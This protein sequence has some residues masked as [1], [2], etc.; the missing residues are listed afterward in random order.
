[1]GLVAPWQVEPSR[2]RDQIRVPCIGRRM[3][4]HCNTREVPACWFWGTCARPCIIRTPALSRRHPPFAA[5]AVDPLCLLCGLE[6]AEV[7]RPWGSDAPLGSPP[8]PLPLRGLG[9]PVG[10]LE[11]V[12]T[13]GLGLPLGG[14]QRGW[15]LQSGNTGASGN[16]L[17]GQEADGAGQREEGPWRADLP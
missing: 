5:A 3:P 17:G 10:S 6:R 16:R 15:G 12:I 2:T 7:W 11:S 9:V 13:G 14:T 4:M 1:M 8:H